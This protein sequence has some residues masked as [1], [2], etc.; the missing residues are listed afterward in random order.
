MYLLTNIDR[1]TRWV[2]AIPLKTME[3]TTCAEHFVSGWEARF[4]VQASVMTDRGAG[5][6]VD[7]GS[8]GWDVGRSTC[9]QDR[10]RHIE[11][12]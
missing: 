3:A 4:G 9:S 8:A 6:A 5:H 7:F 11:K 1:T 10:R 12:S 2:G